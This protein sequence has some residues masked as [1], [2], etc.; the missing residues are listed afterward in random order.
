MDEIKKKIFKKLKSINYPGFNRDIVSFGIIKDILFKENK[1][2]FILNVKTDNSEHKENIKSDIINLINNEFSFSQIT[3]DFLDEDS[4]NKSKN[5]TDSKK[6]IAFASCKGGVGKSTISLNVA[7]ELAKK[8]KVGYLDLDIYGPSLPI[9]ID[10]KSQP[11]F[12]DNKLI[13]INK[14]GIDFMSFGFLNNEDS[15]AIWRGPMVARMTQQFFDNVKWGEL[16][17]LIIDLPPGTGD[18]QLTLVQ[19]IQLTGAVIITTPQD[20][21]L[22]DVR[23][24]SDMFKKVNVPLLGVVENMSKYLIEG[25]INN[26]SSNINLEIGENKNVQID[27]DGKFNL[28]VDIFKGSG[29][30]LESERLNVPLLGK[31]SIDPIL[32]ESSDSGIPYVI[33][34]LN[35]RNYNEFKIISEKISES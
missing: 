7:C 32:S 10:S 27:K 8:Y 31:I 20:L 28:E 16:D 23:K 6:I 24:G 26:Y 21:A 18:I 4:L 12:I 3:V 25:F 15:P 13:P 14:F 2:H 19:K 30:F 17:F 11:S 35:S 29:G 9:M 5:K 22:A 1:I 34:N 33:N